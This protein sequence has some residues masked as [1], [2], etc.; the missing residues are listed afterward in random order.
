MIPGRTTHHALE[1]TRTGVFRGTCAEYCGASHALM[2]FV[3]VVV[4]PDEFRQWMEHQR[5]TARAPLDTLASEGEREFIANG[6]GACHTVRGSTADGRVGPDLT[7]VGGRQRIGAG[8]LANEP[9]AFLRWISQTDV[10]K[11]GVHMP[12]FRALPP[13]SLAALAAYLDGLQ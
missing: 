9:E 6:C 10:V 2:A 11:P 1:P 3:V 8:S 7:H 5:Q 4:E 12:A 13:Q